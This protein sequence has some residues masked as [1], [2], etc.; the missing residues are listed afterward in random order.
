M[1]SFRVCFKNMVAFFELMTCAAY[2][3]TRV[4]YLQIFSTCVLPKLHSK[5]GRIEIL[6][7]RDPRNCALFSTLTDYIWNNHSSEVL[8]KLITLGTYRIQPG[9]NSNGRGLRSV[10]V[11]VKVAFNLLHQWCVFKQNL[12]NCCWFQMCD[13]SYACLLVLMG[14]TSQINPTS[15]Q[16]IGVV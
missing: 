16:E 14:F 3:L 15:N 10:W 9:E 6:D 5:I 12:P 11:I 4:S 7:C 13:S 2:C 8:T 1:A